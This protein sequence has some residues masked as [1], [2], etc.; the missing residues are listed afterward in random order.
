VNG[1][2]DQFT[3][4]ISHPFVLMLL[5]LMAHFGRKMLAAVTHGTDNK[6]CFTD[7][8]KKNPL[9]YRYYR[10]GCGR[11]DRLQELWGTEAGGG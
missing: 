6:P 5:G 9:R 1:Y 3:Q 10:G 4:V 11:D 8:W 2:I 7:Y